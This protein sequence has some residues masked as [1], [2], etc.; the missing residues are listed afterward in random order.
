MLDPVG[1]KDTAMKQGT[2]I[3][4][5]VMLSLLAAVVIYLV[6]SVWTSLDSPFSTVL[7]YSYT[8]DEVLEA[9]GFL[10]REE[11]VITGQSSI[12]DLVPSEGERVSR[13]G[14]V[15]YLYQSAA[16]LERKQAI[17]ALE[18][19]REQLTYSLQQ[20]DL[21]RDM[22]QLG[23]GVISS[24][25]SLRA[26]VASGDLTQLEEE[27]RS[28]KSFVYKRD[29]T[30]GGGGDGA[31][32]G[33]AIQSLDAQIQQLKSQ[34]SQDTTRIS[35]DRSGIF[36]GLVDGY[37]TLLTPTE[38]DGYT[39]SVL[40][41]LAQQKPIAASGAIGK[42]ITDSRWYFICPVTEAEAGLLAEGQSYTVRFSRD[43]SGQ[44]PMTVERIGPPENGRIAIIFST[45]R[46]LSD[47]TLLRRQTVEVL[48]DSTSGIRVPNSAIRVASQT[49]TD[50]ET[51]EETTA[52]VTCVFALVGV[53]A[54]LK[55]V[56]VL[57]QREDFCLVQPAEGT[58]PRSA[59]RPGDEIIVAAA[60]L[61]DGK[62]VR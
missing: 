35:A 45:D 43:W 2:M 8:V 55:P 37:E 7:S 56:T 60:D 25:V 33:A 3:N 26:S 28:L 57:E 21:G 12:V 20:E 38:M 44:L 32:I 14:A 58:D 59:L 42:L 49:V 62:V 18:L 52:Q 22:A 46:Q 5:I 4:R 53:Q 10:V 9:T 17:R 50:P 27:T 51:G 23:S 31:S 13:G 39:P 29:Y 24:I 1:Q 48:F 16:G 6:A 34:A 30:Y 54:E 47:T 19:E 61:H 36:S 41:A 40:D 15:A 11:A